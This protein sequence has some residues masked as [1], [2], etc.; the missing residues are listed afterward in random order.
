[1]GTEEVINEI[2]WILMLPYLLFFFFHILTRATLVCTPYFVT[3][4]ILY[5][6]G[7]IYMFATAHWNA[8]PTIVW[9]YLFYQFFLPSLSLLMSINRFT[10]VIWWNQYSRIWKWKF[11][12]LYSSI[13]LV[14]TLTL[15]YMFYKALFNCTYC[16]SNNRNLY[17]VFKTTVYITA[18]LVEVCAVLCRQKLKSKHTLDKYDVMLLMQSLLS[19]SCF[20]VNI[21]CNQVFDA[22]A[23]DNI[24]KP[25][26]QFI[27]NCMFVM[28]FHLPCLYVFI[29]NKQLRYLLFKFYFINKFWKTE[30]TTVQVSALSQTYY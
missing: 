3:A 9:Q 26:V 14:I 8:L 27:S 25:I 10:A 19:T 12:V 11:F 21:G 30:F 13:I 22:L 5:T 1:M 2:G 16:V 4:T 18:F 24:L 6:C 15:H 20:L 7:S 17:R 29:K 28:G 23:A